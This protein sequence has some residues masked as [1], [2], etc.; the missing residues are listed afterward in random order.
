MFAQESK[1]L[2]NDITSNGIYSIAGN[3][4]NPRYH[5]INVLNENFEIE[6][7]FDIYTN[8]NQ[9]IFTASAP[10]HGVELY[11]TEG[12]S[13]LSTTD[14]QTTFD[15]SQQSTFRVFPNPAKNS[16]TI[17]N[18]LGD[19]IEKI[20][21]FNITGQKLREVKVDNSNSKISSSIE[22]LNSGIYLIKV[23]SNNNTE[24]I[25]IIKN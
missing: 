24:T 17:E 6:Y 9:L 25:K 16:I 4:D 5:P 15:K 22:N 2:F 19:P 8:E 18:I 11:S 13:I 7:I 20:E 23:Y 12:S 1:L 14:F 21:I 10:A 3:E